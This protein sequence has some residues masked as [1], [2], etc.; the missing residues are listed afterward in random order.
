MSTLVETT[1]GSHTGLREGA[2][3]NAV[4]LV[5]RECG[6]TVELG[7]H[8]ACLE[9]FGP[10]EIG[11]DFPAVT[12]EQIEAGPRNIWRYKALLPVPDDI[13]SSPNTEPGFTR[14]L[15]RRQPRRRARDR[16]PVGQGRLD[17]PD[18]L[19]QGPRRG[20]RA[21]RG[22]RVRTPRCSPVRARATSP[23]P[24]PPRAQGPG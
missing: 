5:C 18:Q 20:L 7:P 23:T 13:E 10:L 22:P 19:L 12:R 2:F 1:T 8:Y 21:E 6:A 24:S 14:L 11:Y 17:Q 9:C 4:H 15:K 16:R 3:G